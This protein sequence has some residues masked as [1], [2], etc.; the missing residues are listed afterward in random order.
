MADALDVR[1]EELNF[2]EEARGCLHLAEAETINEVR[3]I[4]MGMAIGWL[5]LAQE[6]PRP[7]VNLSPPVTVEEEHS[8][9]FLPR[10][11]D[12]YTLMAEAIA[13]LDPNSSDARRRLY[14]RARAI[15]LTE[16]RSAAPSDIMAAQ[17]LLELAIGE[18]EADAQ[19]DRHPWRTINAPSTGSPRAY[20]AREPMPG[21]A[22]VHSRSFEA[23]SLAG[24]RLAA[25]RHSAFSAKPNAEK[26]F[27][28]G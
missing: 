16:L 24:A 4:L 12:Y 22:A 8:E 28:L 9:M 27:T 6:G 18:V 11:G 13:A 15:L 14:E 17:M 26:V 5:K 2:R 21:K 25:K 19:R 20:P 23:R 3:T 1:T 10:A 7:L